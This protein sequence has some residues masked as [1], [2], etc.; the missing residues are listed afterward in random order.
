MI[1]VGGGGIGGDGRRWSLAGV[2]GLLAGDA[3]G[4]PAAMMAGDGGWASAL[5][6]KKKKKKS[7]E[8]K[9]GK[10][11]EKEKEK[12]RMMVIGDGRGN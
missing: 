11:K 2:E 1:G 7:E 12:E 9:K 3:A 6:M 8:G 4:A 5:S 10:R